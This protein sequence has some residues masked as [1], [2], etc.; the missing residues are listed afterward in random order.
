MKQLQMRFCAAK[1]RIYIMFAKK[2]LENRSKMRK[3]SHF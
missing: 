3:N 2:N 1:L